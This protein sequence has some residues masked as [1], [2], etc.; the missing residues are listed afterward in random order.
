VESVV[1][2][3]ATDEPLSRTLSDGCR[4]RYVSSTEAKGPKLLRRVE[5]F[6]QC[7]GTP[8]KT[9]YRFELEKTPA[10]GIVLRGLTIEETGKDG[11]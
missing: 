11:R 1:F 4:E 8:T 2:K 10:N 5:V 9:I 7:A 6:R 3:D